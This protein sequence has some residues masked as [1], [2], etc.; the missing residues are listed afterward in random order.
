MKKS[1]SK[2]PRILAI[3]PFYDGFGFALIE[4]LNTLADW[5]IRHVNGDKNASCVAKIKELIVRYQP[6]VI[7][8]EDTSHRSVRR[9]PRIRAL[10]KKIILL[11]KK[12]DVRVMCFSREQVA[13]A[14]FPDG[15][16]TKYNVAQK[17]AEKFS[18]ELGFRLPPKRRPWQ[19]EDSRMNIFDAVALALM[20]R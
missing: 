12:H 3:S 7:A 6:Y 2:Y 14:F 15:H 16:A 5:G 17:V 19:S 8:L 1:L 10:T 13:K 20:V 9:S 18:D 11:A 4:G